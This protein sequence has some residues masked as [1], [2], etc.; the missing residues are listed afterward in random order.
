[1]ILYPRGTPATGTPRARIWKR[2][3]N[4]SW[5][6]LSVVVVATLLVLVIWRGHFEHVAWLSWFYAAIDRLRAA[7]AGH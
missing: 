4:I 2:L 1:M 5:S 3:S 6:I 7:L